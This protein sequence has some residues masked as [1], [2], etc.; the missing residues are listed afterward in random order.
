[1][2]PQYL[3][4]LLISSAERTDF[5]SANLANEIFAVLSAPPN[6]TDSEDIKNAMQEL[7]KLVKVCSKHLTA[8]KLK[9]LLPIVLQMLQHQEV[10]LS[11]GY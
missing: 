9:A 1:M 7:H 3:Q 4:I 11:H 2:Y 10:V 6:A 5:G 8:S